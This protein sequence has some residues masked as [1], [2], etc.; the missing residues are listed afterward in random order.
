VL[1]GEASYGAQSRARESR[2]VV[3]RLVVEHPDAKALNLFAREL[4][5]AGLSFAQGTAGLIGGRPK[6]TPVVRL[7]TFFIDKTRLKLQLQVGDEAVVAVSVPTAGG[8][9]APEA[10]PVRG[11]AQQGSLVEVPLLR[12]A[13]SR[14]GDKGNSSNIAVFLRRPEYRDHVAEWLTPERVAAHFSGTVGGKVTAF[15]APGLSA[16]NFVLEDALGGGG[17]ASMRIDPQGKAYGQRLLE[18]MVPVPR[19]W[20]VT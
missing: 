9:K 1:G 14:S 6:P 16:I 19:E 15:D 17:M 11:S 18:M 13:H 12:L 3:M 10:E 2:E 4:G 5:S 8:Y 20:L 7:F